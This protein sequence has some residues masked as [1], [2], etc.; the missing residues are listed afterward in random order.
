MLVQGSRLRAVTN[1]VANRTEDAPKMEQSLRV[2][3]PLT[4]TVPCELRGLPIAD[5]PFQARTRL[6]PLFP[7]SSK[8]A[9]AAV[10]NQLPDQMFGDFGVT[11][12]L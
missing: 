5:S 1:T 6:E 3:L 7:T 11:L 2:E 4:V 9:S 12:G 10:P 8:S